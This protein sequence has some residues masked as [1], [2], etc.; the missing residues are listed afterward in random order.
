MRQAR[1]K[2][3]RQRKR[4]H[5]LNPRCHW[6]GV[7][8]VLPASAGDRLRKAFNAREATIDHLRSRLDPSRTIPATGGEQRHVLACK[9]CNGERAAAENAALPLTELHRRA[10]NGTS[11]AAALSVLEGKKP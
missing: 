5:A 3:A 7:E 1:S 2:L 4:L 6:C 9:K 10:K 8:T 11:R